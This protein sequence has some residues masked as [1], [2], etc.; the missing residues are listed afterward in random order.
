[1]PHLVLGKPFNPA[2]R[3]YSTSSW[4]KWISQGKFDNPG[5]S[6]LT[7]SPWFVNV[8]DVA[9][10]HDAALL[11][12]ETNHKRLWAAAE[13]PKTVNEFFAIWRKAYPD[14]T[15][16]E[17]MEVKEPPK[18]VLHKEDADALLEKYTG[19]SYVSFEQT[20]IDNIA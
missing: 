10:L 19:R 8:R 4:I 20:I 1:M 17:D 16:P 2:D 13:P 3:E 6:F 12:P 18:T 14:R 15:F 9:A 5:M 7:P 11:D